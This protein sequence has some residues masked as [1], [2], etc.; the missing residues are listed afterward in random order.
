MQTVLLIIDPQVDFCDPDKGAL[1]VRGAEQD[2]HR[3]CG[4]VENLATKLDSI[5]VTLDT[6][7]TVDIAHPPFWSNQEGNEPEPFTVIRASDVACGNWFPRHTELR[8]YALKYLQALEQ[9]GKYDLVVWP[10]HCL[11]GSN[12]HAIQPELQRALC[13]WEKRYQNVDYVLKGLNPLTE[14][15][16]AI[17][18]EVPLPEDPSTQTNTT[19]LET[20]QGADLVLIAGEAGSHCVANTVRDIAAAFGDDCHRL[21]VLTDAISPV[22]GFENLQDTFLT[23]VGRLGVRLAT[24]EAICAELLS[25]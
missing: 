24:T 23:E 5:H 8:D 10:L 6:H 16:S 17:C 2:I 22:P 20:L 19:L 13:A 15:Y 21:V 12:G 7:H 14:H 18:A 11:L 25:A 9:N 4:L 3:I 1:Y